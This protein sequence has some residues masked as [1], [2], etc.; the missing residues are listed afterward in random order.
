MHQL[1]SARV[2]GL[3]VVS[4]GGQGAP[5]AIQCRPFLD[6]VAARVRSAM[7]WVHWGKT[8]AMG[9]ESWGPETSRWTYFAALLTGV[10][11]VCLAVALPLAVVE[12]SDLM[13]VVF[14]LMT[15]SG[16]TGTATVW[17]IHRFARRTKASATD[18]SP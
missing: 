13:W 15:A 8:A 10:Y 9:A 6:I 3:V 4:L 2:G 1:E 18:L 17:G 14:A 5:Q 12:N 7:W 16:V 11:A